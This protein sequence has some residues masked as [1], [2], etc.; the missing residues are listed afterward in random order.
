MFMANLTFYQGCYF[1]YVEAERASYFKF[2]EC[3]CD[4]ADSD[5][6][7]VNPVLQLAKP[8]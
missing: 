5:C 1:I 4:R 6:V 3:I 2:L 8:A 7:Y